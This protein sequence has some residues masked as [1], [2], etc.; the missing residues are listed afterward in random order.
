MVLIKMD[1]LS[2]EVQPEKKAKALVGNFHGLYSLKVAG[3]IRVLFKPNYETLE[4]DIIRVEHRGNA[5]KN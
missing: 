2:E 1:R 4:L 3:S 5:Y